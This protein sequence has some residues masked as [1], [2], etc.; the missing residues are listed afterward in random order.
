MAIIIIIIAVIGIII[1]KRNTPEA[2]KKREAKERFLSA[3]ARRA[4]LY[5]KLDLLNPTKEDNIFF[6]E[7]KQYCYSGETIEHYFD[8]VKLSQLPPEVQ[9][10]YY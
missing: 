3:V 7:Y 1:Y 4:N 5:M 2:K 6:R 10:W 8:R 9:A